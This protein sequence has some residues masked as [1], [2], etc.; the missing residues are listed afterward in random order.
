MLRKLLLCCA[1]LCPASLVWGQGVF[2][3][4]QTAFKIVNGYTTPIAD[5]TI[6]VCAANASGIPCSPALTGTIFKDAALTQPL[7]NPF[8]SDAFG[9]Y[10]FAAA[11]GTYTVTVTASGF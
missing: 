3:P 5:A 2:A 6:T 4:P 8:T 7:S 9:N 1:L 10:Q 11:A